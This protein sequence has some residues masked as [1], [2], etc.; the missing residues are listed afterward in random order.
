MMKFNGKIGRWLIL[1]KKYHHSNKDSYFG[2]KRWLEE[3]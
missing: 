1:V 2:G 3:K